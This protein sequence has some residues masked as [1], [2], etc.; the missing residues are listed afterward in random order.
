[1]SLRAFASRGRRRAW[2]A[3]LLMV[4]V[5]CGPSERLYHDARFTPDGAEIEL[6]ALMPG[7]GCVTLAST[8]AAGGADIEVV[9]RLEGTEVGSMVLSPQKP[10]RVRYDWA[11]ASNEDRYRIAAYRR[12]QASDGTMQ[13]SQDPLVPIGNYVAKGGVVESNCRD[14]MCTFGLLH[15]DQALNANIGQNEVDVR[16]RGVDY[17][18]GGQQLSVASSPMTCGCMAVQNVSPQSGPVHIRATL[19]GEDRGIITLPWTVT[20]GPQPIMLVGFD[21]AGAFSED[22][23]V[24]S[25]AGLGDRISTESPGQMSGTFF[26]QTSLRARD[27]INVIGQIDQLQCSDEGSVMWLPTKSPD[28]G[29]GGSADAPAVDVPSEVPIVCPFGT[30]R[31]NKMAPTIAKPL[32]ALHAERAL[33]PTPQSAPATPP[34]GAAVQGRRP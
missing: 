14:S 2:P 9:A 21:W 1:M 26:T 23:Y 29:T 6:A 7:C 28:V 22:L 11:G 17:T 13:R 12:V 25:V 27:Y 8:G 19:G 5:G 15:M 30:I 4:F 31:M 33:A 24:L 20:D 16:Q 34:A 10:E 18:S 32:P 3:M